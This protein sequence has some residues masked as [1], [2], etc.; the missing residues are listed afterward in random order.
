M[1]E[2]L[3][4]PSD[5]ANEFA[6]LRFVIRQ[7]LLRV[8]TCMPVKVVAC[9][10]AGGVVPVGTVTVQPLINMVAGDGRTF[11]H[12]NLFRVPYSRLQGG[13]NAIIL[14]PEPGDIGLVCF[15]SRDISALKNQEAVDQIKAGDKNGVNPGSARMF[16]MSDGIYVG[17][18]LNGEPEQFVQFNTEGIRIVSPTRVRVEAPTAEVIAETVATIQAPTIELKGN[19]VHTDGDISSTGT[20]TVDVDVIGGGKSLKTHVHTGVTPGG[21]ISGPPQ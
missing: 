20:A 1:A 17:A 15:A 21:G 6:T 8:A 4:K 11:E 2:A 18:I 3:Q 13:T 12:K 7:M 10:N 5:V 14:D 16:D 9:S 19:V